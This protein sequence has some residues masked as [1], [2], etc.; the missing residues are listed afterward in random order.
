MADVAFVVNPVAWDKAFKSWTGGPVGRY[1]RVK[2]NAVRAAA[3][4]LAPGPGSPPRNTT[5]IS[6]GTGATKRSIRTTERHA[7]GG[8]LEG[9]VVATTKQALYV[10][11][12]TRGPY[13]IKP[14][15][16]GGRLRFFGMKTG[17]VVITRRVI[18][19]GVR[20]KQPFLRDALSRVI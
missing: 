2:T 7:A 1:M 15:M 9:H 13:T 19:P 10:H 5:G 20:I 6:Y 18:H 14:R 12:G 16:P 17:A 11:E 3:V 8:D 4:T